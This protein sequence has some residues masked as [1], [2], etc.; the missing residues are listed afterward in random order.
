MQF[1]ALSLVKGCRSSTNAISVM[2]RLV[3]SG[4]GFANPL[5]IPQRLV[6]ADTGCTNAVNAWQ[7]LMKQVVGTVSFR[8]RLV[9]AS[10]VSASGVRNM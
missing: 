10:R 1:A 7:K 6:K 8:Q 9:Q 3:K 2:Q 5:S 4:R